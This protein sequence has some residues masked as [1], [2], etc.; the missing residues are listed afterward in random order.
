LSGDRPRALGQAA[1]VGLFEADRDMVIHAVNPRLSQLVGAAP[2]DLVGRP[3]RT[4]LTRSSQ[5]IYALKAEPFLL[6]SGSA[7]E[8]FLELDHTDGRPRPAL[9]T[10]TPQGPDYERRYGALFAAPERRAYELELIAARQAEIEHVREQHKA[11]QALEEAN[12]RLEGLLVER[13]TALAQRDLLLREVYHR[14]KNNLQ[15]VDGLLFMQ[16]RSLTDAA[17]VD[18]IEGLRKRVFALGLVHHQLMGSADLKTFDIGAFLSELT[19][20]LQ[21]GA[22]QHVTLRIDAAPLTVDLDFAIPLGMLVT[23]LAS[24]ALKHAFPTGTG[25]I[26][27]TLGAPAEGEVVLRLA[28]NGVGFPPASADRKPSQGLSIVDG[29]VRQLGGRILSIQNDGV[30]WEAHLPEPRIT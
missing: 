27:V 12:Q 26:N 4:L 29:L 24:N 2:E 28:D 8:I 13:T 18:A 15:V 11:R 10:V 3:F 19:A 25:E 5:I 17:A 7:E 6:E 9:L 1:P 21:A 20:H 30:C 23:E 22:P 16:T 14:V